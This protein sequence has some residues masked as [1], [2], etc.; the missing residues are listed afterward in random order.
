MISVRQT[1]LMEERTAD[2]RGGGG[3]GGHSHMNKSGMLEFK[4]F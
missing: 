1:S 4:W 2:R 3:G